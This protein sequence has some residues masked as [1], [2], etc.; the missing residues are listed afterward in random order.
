MKPITLALITAF[1]APL[2]YA[3]EITPDNKT[4]PAAS[5]ETKWDRILPFYGEEVVMSGY[6][7]PLPFGIS[8]IYASVQQDMSLTDLA[9]GYNGSKKIDI[10]FISF[11]NTT[12]NTATPHLKLDAWIFPFMNV[13]AT[14]GKLSGSVDINFS[15]DGNVIKEESILSGTSYSLG[16]VLVGGWNSY[17]VAVPVTLSWSE[18]EQD[19][20]GYVVNMLPR[21]GKKF[22]FD[23]GSSLALYAGTSYLQSRLTLTGTQAVSSSKTIEYTIEQRNVDKFMGLAGGNYSFNKHWSMAFEY[24]GIGGGNRQQFISNLTY[25]Y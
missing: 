18:M 13:F 8:V 6:D 9:I 2:A 7:L 22:Q 12:A 21:V 23:N 14:V 3:N 5:Y 11:D 17:F 1:T 20:S 10:D 15:I 4:A 19:A 24:G 25:R 16:T